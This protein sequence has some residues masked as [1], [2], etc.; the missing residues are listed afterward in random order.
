ML[1]E[2][3]QQRLQRYCHEW[4]TNA[5]PVTRWSYR[6]LATALYFELYVCG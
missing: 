5:N 6:K 3:D 2:N 4:H 1:T